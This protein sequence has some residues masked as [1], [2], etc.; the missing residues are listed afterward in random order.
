M[1][2][3]HLPRI[4]SRSNLQ[5]AAMRDIDGSRGE[6][7]GQIVRSAVS[8]AAATGTPIRV[9]NVRAARSNS[10]LR[11]QH[12]TAVEACAAICAADT[13]G[14]SPGSRTFEFV[15]TREP[16]AGTWEWSV[17]T[18]G[19]ATLVLQAALP[20]LLRADGPSRL[21]V[22]GGTHTLHAPIWEHLERSYLPV[23][24]RMEVETEARLERHGFYP[25]GGGR[26]HL[27]IDPSDGPLRPVERRERGSLERLAVTAILADLPGHI[28]RRE[29]ETFTDAL[30]VWE[31]TRRVDAVDAAA[32]PGNAL[33]ATVESDAGV[34]VLSEMGEKGRPAED[35]A[36]QLADRTRRYLDGAA[37]VDVHLADQLLLPLALAGGGAFTT[38]EVTS[39]TRT[40]LDL[41]PEFLDVTFDL[42]ETSEGLVQ[43]DVRPQ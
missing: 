36:R 31:F 10:G 7:G 12:E 3:A 4:A 42:R 2:S 14:V 9:T 41:I 34:V 40:Q 16:V 5:R 8:L 37:A 1:L 38:R 11:P 13:E 32:S 22:E 21:T 35:V 19:S 6:G 25:A 15:P 18:A 43:I 29:L 30:S 24:E 39:H 17:E 33:F 23:L 28:A 26:V 27:E 20:P